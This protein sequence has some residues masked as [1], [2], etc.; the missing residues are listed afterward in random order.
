MAS[1]EGENDSLHRTSIRAFLFYVS[2]DEEKK[3]TRKRRHRHAA[4]LWNM[5]LCAHRGKKKT[6]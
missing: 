1:I 5:R 6:K 2:M 4:K 3:E